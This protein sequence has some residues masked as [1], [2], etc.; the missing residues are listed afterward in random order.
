MS[1]AL[2]ES[3]VL[4]SPSA[5]EEGLYLV[6]A[7]FS[8]DEADIALPLPAEFFAATDITEGTAFRAADLLT[9]T[10][11]F[12]CLT[13]LAPPSP[14]PRSPRPADPPPHSGVKQS[15]HTY[16]HKKTRRLPSFVER[17]RRAYYGE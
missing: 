14:E 2:A 17:S 12:L 3:V 16:Q 4:A 1:R 7:N 6:L 8:S 13:T 9:G 5:S 11:D 10:V 15:A